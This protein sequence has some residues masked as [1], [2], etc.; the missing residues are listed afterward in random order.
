MVDKECFNGVPGAP[1][2]RQRE[3]LAKPPPLPRSAKNGG[4]WRGQT[5]PRRNDVGDLSGG[6]LYARIGGKAPQV[7]TNFGP[8]DVEAARE[9]TDS[10]MGDSDEILDPINKPDERATV[11]IPSSI[12][13]RSRH[14]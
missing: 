12:H 4:G 8:E 9:Q 14:P 6:M 1:D 10:L 13:P 3:V 2:A 5:P 11:D 7:E